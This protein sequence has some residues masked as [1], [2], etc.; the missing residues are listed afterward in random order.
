VHFEKMARPTGMY[1]PFNYNALMH[2]LAK[3][4]AIDPLTLFPRLSNHQFAG[5]DAIGKCAE[6]G[7]G[8]S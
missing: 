5:S 6:A 1:I 3:K 7:E 2:I 8:L 4:A